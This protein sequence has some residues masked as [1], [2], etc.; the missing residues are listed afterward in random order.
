MSGARRIGEFRLIS[1]INHILKTISK[2][3]PTRLK[4]KISDLIYPSQSTYLHDRSILDSVVSAQE[5]MIACTKYNWPAFFLKLDFAKA[6]DTIDWSFL[7]K[8]LQARSF[9]DRWYGWIQSLLIF[10]FSYVLV[11]EQPEAPSRCKRG[12][13]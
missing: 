9:G 8:V 7:L 11:N 4:K 1:L 10:G 5:I 12:L 13:R 6:F 3:L 2:I